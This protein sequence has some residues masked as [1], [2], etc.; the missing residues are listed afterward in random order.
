ML[1]PSSESIHIRNTF[2]RHTMCCRQCVHLEL[3]TNIII[4][5]WNFRMRRTLWRA[6]FNARRLLSD[7]MS[8]VLFNFIVCIK[9]IWKCGLRSSLSLKIMAMSQLKSA[10][11]RICSFWT[12]ALSQR[13][14]ENSIQSW[15]HGRT[16]LHFVS[17]VNAFF[18]IV[19]IAG[20]NN[21]HF[22]WCAVS[23]V[24]HE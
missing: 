7:I 21:I 13:N 11:F 20:I 12:V 1:Y 22:F 15:D 4:V 10:S 24:Y 6:G 16:W 17:I 3:R 9:F 5:K 19:I 8:S 23:W 18:S 2:Y 14:D